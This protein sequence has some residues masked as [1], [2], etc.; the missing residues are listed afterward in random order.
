MS[1]K[2]KEVWTNYNAVLDHPLADLPIEG[3][4]LT[5]VPLVIPS[6]YAIAFSLFI[7]L[8]CQPSE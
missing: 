7:V 6:T 1:R 2:G 8:S 4:Q 5:K 3:A